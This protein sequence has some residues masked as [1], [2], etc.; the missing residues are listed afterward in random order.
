MSVITPKFKTLW[1]Y[2]QLTLEIRHFGVLTS[3]E[4]ATCKFTQSLFQG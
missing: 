1:V 3:A 4:T 2:T